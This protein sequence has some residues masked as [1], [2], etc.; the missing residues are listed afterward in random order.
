MLIISCRRA[1]IVPKECHSIG[2]NSGTSSRFLL[3]IIM[4]DNNAILH[5]V[6]GKIKGRNLPKLQQSILS[7][8][9]TC[10]LHYP[11]VDLLFVN[12]PGR[13]SLLASSR[14]R[15]IHIWKPI[16]LHSIHV[17]TFRAWQLSLRNVRLRKQ[18]LLKSVDI[19]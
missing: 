13:S 2:A 14:S 11:L 16:H 8:L 9:R 7:C 17:G 15:H 19:Q 1:A 6:I 4:E 5:T 3:H 18:K 10:Q 12:L